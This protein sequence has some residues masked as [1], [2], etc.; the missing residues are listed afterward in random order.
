LSNRQCAGLCITTT[1]D[2]PRALRCL[3]SVF[4]VYITL[5]HDDRRRHPRA[6]ETS[7]LACLD[8]ITC[9]CDGCALHF[10]SNGLSCGGAS[11]D[12]TFC[13]SRV[14]NQALLASCK[15]QAFS[16]HVNVNKVLQRITTATNPYTTKKWPQSRR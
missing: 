8:V 11:A 15:V 16:L 14:R 3:F 6:C 9:A 4:D 12:K 5:S 7:R 2:S 1:H 10:G 13:L